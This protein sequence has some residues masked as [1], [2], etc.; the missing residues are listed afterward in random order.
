MEW[1][2][3]TGGCEKLS[4]DVVWGKV[5]DSVWSHRGT[6][7]VNGAPK[8]VLRLLCSGTNWASANGCPEPVNLQEP[9]LLL[10]MSWKDLWMPCWHEKHI[11]F[12]SVQGWSKRLKESG[13]SAESLLHPFDSGEL[14]IL[15]VL[16]VC[17]HSQAPHKCFVSLSPAVYLSRSCSCS[18]STKLTFSSKHF[19]EVL[20]IFSLLWCTPILGLLLHI[21][22]NTYDLYLLV[23]FV[24]FR[25]RE[26]QGWQ[27]IHV[28]KLNI[29]QSL[30]GVQCTLIEYT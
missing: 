20:S 6:L 9:V 28:C 15:Q 13:Q 5:P 16:L 3:K 21:I 11:E 23:L 7:C 29:F 24:K 8:S 26:R 10:P 4:E 27:L 30:A 25:V 22:L 2:I 17:L 18:F 1:W 14:E 12:R 19:P